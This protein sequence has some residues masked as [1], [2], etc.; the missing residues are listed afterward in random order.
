[1]AEGMPGH[2]DLDHETQLGAF[3]AAVAR[4][5]DAPAVLYFDGVL[6]HGELDRRATALDVAL[7]DRGFST[8]DRLALYLQNNPAF[9][10]GL[11]A[12]WKAGG[13]AVAVNPMN[14]HR[15]LSYLLEDSGARAILCL[16]ELWEGV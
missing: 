8:G 9:L 6:S 11:L 16:E 7:Q 5:S 2:M 10:I 13:A 3:E 1:Y 12:A 4:D 15:E 14:L